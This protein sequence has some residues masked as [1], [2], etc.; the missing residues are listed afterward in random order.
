MKPSSAKAK[1][2][3]FQQEIRDMMLRWYPLHE[4]D[5]RSTS[6]GASGDDL[7]L[8]PRAQEVY[9]LAIECKRTE[10]LSI[11]L[12]LKQACAHASGRPLTPAL[13]FR[14]NRSDA[15]ACIPAEELVRLYARLHTVE[16]LLDD[17]DRG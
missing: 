14:R 2:R 11:W 6:M 15:W 17:C 3:L 9:P 13:F 8:S 12:A 5:V 7:L 16:A 1:G 4:D 10:K